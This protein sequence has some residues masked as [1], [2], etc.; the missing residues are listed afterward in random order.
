M[1]SPCRFTTL[2][3][4]V[5]QILL[6][7]SLLKPAIE[8]SSHY[9]Y[10]NTPLLNWPNQVIGCPL[11]VHPN[12]A[13]QSMDAT[14]A[15]E[16][17]RHL[18]FFTGP[19]PATP[20]VDTSPKYLDSQAEPSS[21]SSIARQATSC[22]SHSAAS[23]S[24]TANNRK[25]NLLSVPSEILT[26]ILEILL[27]RNETSIALP[28]I[29]HYNFPDLKP[30]VS[31]AVL[32][33]CKRLNDI[34]KPLLY[35]RNVF[36]LEPH[37]RPYASPTK[38]FTLL[39]HKS[40]ALIEHLEVRVEDLD[41]HHMPPRNGAICVGLSEAVRF[42]PYPYPGG[43]MGNVQS[44][45]CVFQNSIDTQTFVLTHLDMGEEFRKLVLEFLSHP[46]D[47][48]SAPWHKYADLSRKLYDCMIKWHA[49]LIAAT[50]R[51]RCPAFNRMLHVWQKIKGDY[52]PQLS[53]VLCRNAEG[54]R[55]AIA[56]SRSRCMQ[57]DGEL[58]VDVEEGI[59][60]VISGRRAGYYYK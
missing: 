58:E 32:Q 55:A 25:T 45:Q 42:Y 5:Y 47:I 4:S 30:D 37:I 14:D 1:P 31:P 24:S 26:M 23:S 60:K 43:G 36:N 49:L 3:L 50:I 16:V 12:Q 2:L 11:Q 38:G 18:E 10:Q 20:A 44:I 8:T 57:V 22:L 19:L 52:H 21:A 41:V 54:L 7:S 33:T 48:A 51:Q 17:Q 15:M 39:S 59:V 53:I 40:L 6:F 46:G 35:G 27:V 34:G 13:I 9:P 29:D 56:M 28:T